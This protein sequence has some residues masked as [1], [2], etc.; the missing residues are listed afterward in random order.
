MTMTRPP[1]NAPAG[2][3]A[4]EPGDPGQDPFRRASFR[5]AGIPVTLTP[6]AYLLGVLLNFAYLYPILTAKIIP[7]T[8]WLSHMWY[9]GWI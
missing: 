2:P 9:H 6:G 4:W 1:A 7:Y 5:V 8:S 3:P